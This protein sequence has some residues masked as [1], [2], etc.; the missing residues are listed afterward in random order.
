MINPPFL[1]FPA[2]AAGVRRWVLGW[3]ALLLLALPSAGH[4]LEARVTF[5]HANTYA[6]GAWTPVRVTLENLPEK[7]G[8]GRDFSG[9][10]E[11]R[12]S[13]YR[14]AP[15]KH[16]QQIE[17]PLHSRKLVEFE[18]MLSPN[19]M[20]VVEL[21]DEKAGPQVRKEVH[22]PRSSNA[23]ASLRH[24]IYV[25]PTVLV[26]QSPTET[27][28]LPFAFD[29]A[30]A[31]IKTVNAAELPRDY[32]GFDSVRLVVVRGHLTER[33]RPDQLAALDQWILLGGRL[34]VVT[35]RHHQ[36][37]RDDPWL[38]ARLPAVPAGV[39][40][41]TLD[42]LAA[43]AGES[44]VLVTRW[45]SPVPDE[46][47]LWRTAA[48]PAAIVARH[49][50]GAVHA[51]G[52]DPSGFGPAEMATPVG[53]SVR[54]LLDVWVLGPGREDVRA[55]HLWSTADVDP[56]F[57]DVMLLPNLWIVTLLI[58]LFVV[59]VGPLNFL[60]L[61]RRRQLE[62]AWL[63]IP[64]FSI[65]FFAAVYAYGAAA[66][67]GD[68]HFA[69]SDILH[70][71]PD[72][73]EGF[74]LTSQIQFAP[75]KTT[76]RLT[77]PEGGVV[78]PLNQYYHD[79]V[80]LNAFNLGNA[81][82]YSALNA[83]GG[84]AGSVMPALV[85]D[86]T[87]RTTLLRPVEQWTMQFYQGEAPWRLEGTMDGSVHL[88]HD[89]GV[90]FK[91]SNDTGID[92]ENAVLYLGEIQ[93]PVGKIAAG[94]SVDRTLAPTG[95]IPVSIPQRSTPPATGVGHFASSADFL[96]RQGG[97]RVY[98]HFALQNPQRRARL[99]ATNSGWENPVDV[100]PAPDAEKSYGLVEIALPVRWEGDM[101]FTTGDYL[102]REV[103]AVDS[104]STQIDH[105][106]N[107]TFCRLR[108][109]A[110]EVLIGNP[111]DRTPAGFRAGHLAVSFVPHSEDLVVSAFDYDSGKWIPAY[112]SSREANVSPNAPSHAE[113]PI[114]PA[115]VNPA[116]PMIRLRLS[117]VPKPA[118][119]GAG[120]P[121]SMFSGN[122]GVE[123]VS[124]D[125]TM[126]LRQGDVKPLPAP[127]RKSVETQEGILNL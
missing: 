30:A 103:Y 104:L 23:F 56:G 75:R 21:V 112:E 49:G 95:A 51:M 19:S 27:F 53:R 12:T 87:G 3:A 48:G 116:D 38:A 14:G 43:G 99:V 126:T 59:V 2:A 88:G 127:F 60:I 42:D 69:S 107:S 85:Q 1:S 79:P 125:A 54:G 74:L 29:S 115:W 40:E 16:R 22:P 37:I 91:F 119:A 121:G 82:G 25:V 18:V 109:S 124:L 106:A 67:G 41:L 114:D 46:D 15:M 47:V 31:N 123:I 93:Y 39:L 34:A 62:M 98:P 108:D 113:V 61:R 64:G 5:G 101:L 97:A 100:Q 78:A 84:D 7:S 28:S 72:S 9:H 110:V 8:T 77:P 50:A 52:L 55:R 70:L 26:L 94:E 105:N 71:A 118:S 44:P 120:G 80:N 4:A 81:F 33:L 45:D 57:E 13:D 32:R 66:K 20:I 24:S 73:S 92:L 65:L 122:Q 17:L 35:P 90:E 63:T 36:E 6:A 11:V 96:I 86:E 76:Y 102:R 89:H 58:V 111:W 68:Q 83:P 10:V 117:A